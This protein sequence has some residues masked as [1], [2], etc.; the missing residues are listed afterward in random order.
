MPKLAS[1]SAIDA[2]CHIISSFHYFLLSTITF[3]QH[4]TSN[5]QLTITSAAPN[6]I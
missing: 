3:Q 1:S 5:V 4:I 2:T 6:L